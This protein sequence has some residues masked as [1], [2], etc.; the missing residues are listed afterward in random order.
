[1]RDIKI[2]KKSPAERN[3]NLD[4]LFQPKNDIVFWSIGM[5]WSTSGKFGQRR[6]YGFWGEYA[7]PM[8]PLAYV[9]LGYYAAMSFLGVKRTLLS[10]AVDP[11]RAFLLT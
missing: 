5:K 9:V 11:G 1:M 4:P 3:W 7:E 8:K 10:E 6:W 2:I